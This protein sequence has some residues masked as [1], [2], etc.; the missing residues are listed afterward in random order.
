MSK[1]GKRLSAVNALGLEAYLLGVVARE[2]PQDWPLEALKAQ[3]VAARTYSLTR[4]VQGKPFD[5]YSDQRSQMYG[6]VAGESPRS[7]RAVRETAGQ[8]VLHAG[9]LATTF[10]FASS[11]GRTANGEDV[12]GEPVPYLVSVPDPWDKASPNHVWPP[13]LLTGAAVGKAFGLAGPAV[14]AISVPTPSGRPKTVTL[15]T[16]AGATRHRDAAPTCARGSGCSPSTSGSACCGSTG[17]A[18]VSSPESG[19][20]SPVSLG[21]WPTLRWSGWEPAAGS[22]RRDCR[23]VRTALLPWTSARRVDTRFR[24]SASGFAGPPILV[25]VAAPRAS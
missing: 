1:E 10:Y 18:G 9:A 5:L 21:M 12:F 19:S 2:M 22:G 20:A 16:R 17:L 23:S 3:A 7:T 13:R 11:G 4:F 25:R 24:L 6:G 8:V 15:S 14:D